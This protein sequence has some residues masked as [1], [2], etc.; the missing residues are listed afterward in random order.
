M[1]RLARMLALAALL[2]G[3]LGG[4]LGTGQAAPAAQLGLRLSY[5]GALLQGQVRGASHD[6]L[7][8]V[9]STVGRA[10]LLRCAPRCV[11]TAALPLS[12][13]LIL[14]SGSAYRVVLG[15]KFRPGQRVMLTLRLRSGQT[16]NAQAVVTR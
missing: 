5:G 1:K 14:G 6:A 11:T 8:G 16:L 3:L 15:G 7:T 9:W 13:T 2:A 10:R 12:G 4:F